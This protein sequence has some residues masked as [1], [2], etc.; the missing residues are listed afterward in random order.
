MSIRHRLDSPHVFTGRIKGQ[1]F[2]DL[3]RQ[4]EEA[5]KQYRLEGVTFHV[6]RHTAASHL[7]MSGVPLAT[8]K[9]ILRHKDYAMTLRYAHLSSEHTKAAVDALGNSPTLGPREEAKSA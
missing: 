1:P 7:V 4:F 8:A 3:K 9:E 5:V 6:L 2:W